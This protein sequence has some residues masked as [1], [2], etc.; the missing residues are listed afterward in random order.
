M[1][2]HKQGTE[3]DSLM[4]TGIP[5]SGTQGAGLQQTP[6]IEGL[7]NDV[8]KTSGAMH[9]CTAPKITVSAASPGPGVPVDAAVDKKPGFFGK[10]KQTIQAQLKKPV[11]FWNKTDKRTMLTASSCFLTVMM[12][13]AMISLA[14]VAVHG[15][16]CPNPHPRVATSPERVV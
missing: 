16:S 12:L 6:L 1:S 10:L 5:A 3:L 14:V 13:C 7:E 8:E 11:V 2:D 15:K 4:A 9:T